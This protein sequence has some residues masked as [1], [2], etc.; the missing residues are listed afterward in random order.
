MLV[1]ASC[2]VVRFGRVPSAADSCPGGLGINVIRIPGSERSGGPRV[3]WMRGLLPEGAGALGGA[4]LVPRGTRSVLRRYRR[5]G[6]DVAVAREG[7]LLGEPVEEAF[8][9][10]GAYDQVADLG[11]EDAEPFY[12]AVKLVEI[13]VKS[14]VEIAA[15]PVESA[16]N[17]VFEAVELVMDGGHPVEKHAPEEI[18]LEQ[19]SGDQNEPAPDD[20]DGF[21]ADWT[22]GNPLNSRY[23]PGFGV[24][25]SRRGRRNPAGS[26]TPKRWQACT[27]CVDAAAV[28]G[29]GRRGC[30]GCA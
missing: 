22:H 21:P 13:A 8:D 12:V 9:T 3:R 19:D 6:R 4:G 20:D 5:R 10:G 26:R 7:A 17:S 28:T 16:A 23:S 25:R 15:N 24:G 29:P 30:A 14:V 2:Q 18:G 27:R 1:R 11:V